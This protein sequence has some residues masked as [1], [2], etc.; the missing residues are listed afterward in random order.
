M[1]EKWGT[2]NCMD[3]PE[4]RTKVA[5]TQKD[6]M[7]NL[8]IEKIHLTNKIYLGIQDDRVVYKCSKCNKESSM[9]RVVLNSHLRANEDFCKY[10]NYKS[11]FRS[12]GEIDIYKTLCDEFP[13]LNIAA[14]VKIGNLEID[15]LFADKKLGIEYNGLYWHSEDYKS[16]DYH[17]NKALKLES[18]GYSIIQVWEDDWYLKRNQVIS[19]IRS[20]LGL[21]ERRWA[22]KCTIKEVVN[23]DFFEINHFDGNAKGAS[24]SIG[25]YLDDVL[26]S[27]ISLGKSR[28]NK[29]YEWEL[30]RYATLPNITVVGGFAKMLKH[31]IEKWRPI[32]I[33]TYRKRDFGSSVFYEKAGFEKIDKTRPNYF[34]IVDGV[35]VS[36]H[37]Y[38]KRKIQGI[39]ENQT[40]IEWMHLRGYRRIWDC[41][42]DI[43]VYQNQTCIV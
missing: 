32:N 39:A 18:L 33:M 4:I 2:T 43:Y 31:F 8:L 35:R 5:N 21:N 29:N 13:E 1:L 3:I 7:L 42:S 20:K 37:Q 17:Q 6:K 12:K 9:N 41:G 34:W 28:F 14:N 26:I 16:F 30:L 23:K 11:H 36:R 10:C 22:R 40:E 19:L 24:V 38:Q 27:A 25:L 15:I